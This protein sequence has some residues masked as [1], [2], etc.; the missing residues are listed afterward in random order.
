MLVKEIPRGPAQGNWPPR[1]RFGVDSLAAAVGAEAGWAGT[2]AT[3][4]AVPATAADCIA[5]AHW[6]GSREGAFRP[7]AQIWSLAAGLDAIRRSFGGASATA[8]AKPNQWLAK[9]CGE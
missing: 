9:T 4:E 3:V 7:G 6:V 5:N 8:A 1:G 2:T